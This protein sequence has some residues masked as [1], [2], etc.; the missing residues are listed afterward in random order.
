MSRN[1]QRYSSRRSVKAEHS[2]KREIKPKFLEARKE[3]PKIVPITEK[4]AEYLRLIESKNCVIATGLAGTGKTWLPTVVACD[5]WLKGDI[6]RIVLVRP[7]R[8]NSPSVGFF[9]GSVIEKM[10]LWLMPILGTLNQRLTK[11]VVDEAIKD[12]MIECLPLETI[13]GRSFSSDTF[14]ICDEAS[15]LTVEEMKSILTRQG[16][17]KMVLCGDIEQSALHE[18]SGML[19]ASRLADKYP[20]LQKYVG[21][22]DFSD[23]SDVVRSA[24]CREWIKV[25]HKEG[26]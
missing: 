4:Q 2:D 19:F 11:N 5:L 3:Q 16:G 22:V 21:F 26:L 9:G 10:S 24:E 8:S 17:G 15:D 23:Y 18:K 25:F 13:K 6:E 14:V 12:G 1:A 20:H 7:A